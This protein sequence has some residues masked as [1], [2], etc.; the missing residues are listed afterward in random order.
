[1][2]EYEGSSRG[3]AVKIIG[4]MPTD[5]LCLRACT[6][7]PHFAG[8]QKTAKKCPRC[9]QATEKAEGCNKIMCGGCGAYW[10]WKCGKEIDGYKHFRSGDCILFDEA[11]IL[12]WGW[13]V[14]VL[15][16]VGWWG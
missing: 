11:E 14:C 15:G 4:G 1:M 5:C 12:R 16:V 2:K 9:G 3:A 10:C 7:V 13:C 6:C 8:P